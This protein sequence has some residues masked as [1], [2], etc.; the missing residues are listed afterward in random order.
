MVNRGAPF[1]DSDSAQ[2]EKSQPG[3][4]TPLGQE[5]TTEHV[6]LQKQQVKIP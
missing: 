1:Q 3:C 4:L 6:Q 2:Q 5:R